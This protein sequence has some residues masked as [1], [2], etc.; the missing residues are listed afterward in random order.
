MRND[1]AV[2]R[3]KRGGERYRHAFSLVG[4]CGYSSILL[5]IAMVFAQIDAEKDFF[6]GGAAAAAATAARP[7]P[8]RGRSCARMGIYKLFLGAAAAA[9]RP[10]ALQM[11]S[12]RRMFQKKGL[13]IQYAGL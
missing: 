7:H 11:G 3:L 9:L 1:R 12:S 13:G 2:G 4:G 6:L 8:L 5:K 10:G